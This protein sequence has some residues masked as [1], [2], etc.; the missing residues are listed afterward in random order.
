MSDLD[1]MLIEAQKETPDGRATFSDQ[2]SLGFT[3]LVVEWARKEKG[4][5]DEEIEKLFAE[6]YM[7]VAD[8]YPDI[9]GYIN[10]KG[11]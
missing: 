5:S 7:W 4:L 6:F 2:D 8:K 10:K 1:A 9:M 11:S 3:M